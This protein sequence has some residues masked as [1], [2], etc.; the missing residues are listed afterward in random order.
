VSL[1]QHARFED[2]LRLLWDNGG[3]GERPRHSKTY[4]FPRAALPAL[5]TLPVMERLQATLMFAAADD[6]DAFDLR[7]E[8]LSARGWRILH[9]LAGAAT[10]KVDRRSE[11]IAAHLADGW[12]V[13]DP[14][15]RRLLDL[16]L[17]LCADHELNVSAFA[18]RVVASTASSPYH[19]VAAGL[20]ALRGLRHGGS[21]EAVEAFLD[22]AVSSAAMRRRIAARV[23]RRLSVPGFGHPLYPHGDPRAK[24]LRTAIEARWPN[25]KP[26]ELF[27]DSTDIGRGLLGEEPNLDFGLVMLRRALGLPR[28][29]AMVLFA[30]GRTAGWMAHLMEQCLLNQLI[31]PRASY[32]GPLPER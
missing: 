11:S 32:I 19:A 7:P 12:N 31:R 25:S 4:S 26:A 10:L 17:I 3:A 8:M 1:A 29:A 20:S 6:P 9:L 14:G 18:V 30:L 2:V 27:R 22:G 23:R 28:G 15:A 13:N 21:S 16:A 24:A 5:S